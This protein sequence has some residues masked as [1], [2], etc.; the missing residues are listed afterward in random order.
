MI[1]EALFEAEEKMDKAVEYLRNEYRGVRTGR[2]S[3]GLVEHVKVNYY[4]APT[5]LRQLATISCPD[6]LLIAI[7]PYDPGSTQD[8]VKAIQ[9]SDIGI[10]PNSDGKVIRLSVPPLSEERRKQI[11]HQL[12]DMAEEAR[13]SLRNIRRDCI[14]AIEAEQK[15]KEISEDDAKRGEKE[16]TD[17]VHQHEKAVDEA[18]QTKT[19]EVMES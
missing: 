7:K 17:M 11:V 4:G 1:D 5:E 10:T 19:D 12:K 13:V 15:A 14:K 9:A 3:A 6:A 2:A 8:I 16:A 18:L